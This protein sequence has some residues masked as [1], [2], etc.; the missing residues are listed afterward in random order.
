MQTTLETC[1]GCLANVDSPHGDG[2]DHAKCPG[3]GEQ[4]IFHDCEVGGQDQPAIWHGVDPRA[5]V[6]RE[7]NW[8]TTAVGIDHLVEDYTR[9]VV[10]VAM[11]MVRWN[12]DTQRH[13]IGTVDNAEIDRAMAR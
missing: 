6:A 4:L 1:P 7:L 5:E 13:D 11:D 10:A 9:V 12:P 8:W 2:C 3:C